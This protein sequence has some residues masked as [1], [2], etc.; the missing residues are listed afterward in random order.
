MAPRE[1]L[2][3]HRDLIERA[4][5]YPPPEVELYFRH[6]FG[7]MGGYV[8]E[9]IF[10][11][12]GSEGVALKFPPETQSELLQQAPDAHHLVWTRQY[13]ILPPYILEDEARL[14][15]WLQLS[16]D[17]VLSQPRKRRR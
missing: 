14:S 15:E 7:G 10:A 4:M 13:L 1:Q 16:I 9:R 11:I 12:L 2:L 8:R 17:Y 5:P 6:M 3:L